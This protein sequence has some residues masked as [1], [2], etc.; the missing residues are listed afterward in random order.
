MKID[1]KDIEYIA[2]LS[3]IELDE[4]EKETFTHQLGGILSYIEKLNKLT[5]DDVTPLAYT[6]DVSNVFR[7]DTSKNSIPLEDVLVNAPAIKGVF[8]KV[9]K[10]LE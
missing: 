8:F 9:P 4:H 6:M 1:K 10:V 2:N 7:E 3:R 5:T